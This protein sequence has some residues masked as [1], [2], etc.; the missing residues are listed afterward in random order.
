MSDSVWKIA[1]TGV[2]V[3]VVALAVWSNRWWL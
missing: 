3:V 2:C 1:V